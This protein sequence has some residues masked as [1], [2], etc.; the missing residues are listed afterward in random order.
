MRNKRVLTEDEKLMSVLPRLIV[1]AMF[2]QSEL[3]G[4][5]VPMRITLDLLGF[6]L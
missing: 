4:N 3:E 1:V 5:G 2:S 6:N